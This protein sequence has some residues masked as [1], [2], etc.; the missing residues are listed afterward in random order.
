[1][2]I[3]TSELI[4]GTQLQGELASAGIDV[5][6]GIGTEADGAI[7][8]VSTYDANGTA[9]DLPE[10]AQV[11]V[12]AHDAVVPVDPRIEVIENMESLTDADKAALIGLIIG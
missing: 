1:M 12:D 5:A 8:T 6:A 3:T 4:N 9:V 7:L 11:V 2:A 10:A